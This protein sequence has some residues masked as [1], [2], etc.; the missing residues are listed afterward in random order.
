MGEEICPDV[1]LGGACGAAGYVGLGLRKV[2][3]VG[4]RDLGALPIKTV[5]EAMGAERKEDKPQA[6]P[7]ASG[8]GRVS[9]ARRAGN[10]QLERQEENQESVVF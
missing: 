7:E 3:W 6:S 5:L 2:T 8:P 1:F 9:K 10:K 4:G